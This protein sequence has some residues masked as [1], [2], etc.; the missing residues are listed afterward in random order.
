V[1]F[2]G[3]SATIKSADASKLVV[4]VPPHKTGGKVRVVVRT[5]D[6]TFSGPDFEYLP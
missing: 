1:T 2:G 4:E 3:V 6:A 5:P